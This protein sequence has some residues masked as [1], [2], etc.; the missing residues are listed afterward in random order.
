M[1]EQPGVELH[2]WESRWESVREVR[3][4]DPNNALPQFVDIVEEF[5]AARGYALDEPVAGAG[6]EPEIAATY[7][8]ARE[9]AERAAL[10]EASR[11]EVEDALGDLDDVFDTLVSGRPAG[12]TD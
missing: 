6:V 8:A 1:S 4:D 5:L 2:D 3:A 7:R 10:G 11:S 9:T 12:G